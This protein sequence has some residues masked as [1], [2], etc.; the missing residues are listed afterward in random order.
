MSVRKREMIPGI[1]YPESDGQP[2]GETDIHIQLMIDL[3]SALQNYFRDERNVYVGSNML[4][5]YVEGNP[6][7]VL[8][9][10]VFVVR[11]INKGQRRIYK[12]WEEGRPPGIVIELSSR[13]TWREDLH[14]KWRLY[15]QMGVKEYFIFDPEYDYLPE[16]F[17]GYRLKNNQ[18]VA[19][20][21][22]G[23]RV[24][25]DVLGMELVDTGETLRLLDLK[26]N[27]FLLTP[28]EEAEAHR[29][30]A[31]ARHRAETEVAQLRQEI[32]RLKKAKGK[33]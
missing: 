16:P 9:P 28:L 27:K 5:Y 1:Y 25:S 4:L 11:G 7:K 31:E 22:E 21:I 12:L 24:R 15:E 30:E 3:R 32:E 18:Y 19:M 26:T 13:K 23:G 14:L 6:K 8:A 10:D 29:A 17:V 2:M 33:K 20:K